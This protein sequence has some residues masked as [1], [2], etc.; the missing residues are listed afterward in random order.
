MDGKINN[1][2]SLEDFKNVYRV[3]SEPPYNEEYTDEEIADIFNEYK[4]NGYI[5][6]AYNGDECM[7]IVVI[8]RGVKESQPVSFEDDK[9]MYL[10]DVAVL[11]K[12]RRSGLGSQLMLYAVLQSKALGYNKLYMRTLEKDKSMSYRIAKKIGF[13]QIQGVYQDVERERT[14]GAMETM[15]NIFLDIDLKTFDRKAALNAINFVCEREN[16]LEK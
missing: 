16:D 3:F 1:L 7:G 10:A 4:E 14:N 9:I 2:E 5:Y 15:K 8:E 11:D 6:G 12:Y 13:S